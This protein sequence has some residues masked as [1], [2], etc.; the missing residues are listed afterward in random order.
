MTFGLWFI[1]YILGSF[2]RHLP[3]V[4]P[5]P[6]SFG[7]GLRTVVGFVYGVFRR[8]VLELP[9]DTHARDM[10]QGVLQPKDIAYYVLFIAF[11]LFLT[12]R[13]LDSRK[14]RA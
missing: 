3:E 9:I 1:M 6:D 12:F 2:G 10:A 7:A 14:W 11:F 8:L 5:A 4:N 13:A